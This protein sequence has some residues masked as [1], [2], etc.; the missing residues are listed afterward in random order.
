MT[1]AQKCID[2]IPWGTF[3]YIFENPSTV[4]RH[5]F[6]WNQDVEDRIVA[7]YGRSSPVREKRD[8]Y[9]MRGPRC[10]REWGEADDGYHYDR[11]HFAAHSI[12]G[13]ADL[14]L[15]PQ[16]RDINRGRS[17]RGRVYR[18]MER[19][20]LNNPGLFCFARPVYLDKSLHPFYLEFGILRS[21]L[22]FWVELFENRYTDKLFVAPPD[23]DTSQD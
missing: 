16:R 2:L 12:G 4:I 14:G 21:D 19:Y 3:N 8:P 18:S 17:P 10:E 6:V 9:R 23:R 15:F 5:D 22:T 7:V 20:C 1:P 13:Q 11:G